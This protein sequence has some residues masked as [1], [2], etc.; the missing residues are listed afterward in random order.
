[1]KATTY[2]SDLLEEKARSSRLPRCLLLFLTLSSC[3]LTI[4][5]AQ[6]SSA[7]DTFAQA[8]RDLSA[9]YAQ[10]MARLSL[11][12]QL[13]LREAERAW[14]TLTHKNWAAW[15]ALRATTGLTDE[16]MKGFE[17]AEIRRRTAH[18][19]MFF[20]TFRFPYD[21]SKKVRDDLNAELERQLRQL[22]S[23]IPKLEAE[24]DFKRVNDLT[25]EVVKQEATDLYSRWPDLAS[26][27]KRNIVENI[28]Q[29]IVVDAEKKEILCGLL[30][31]CQR[32]IY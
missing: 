15:L 13:A 23:D 7:T 1:M 28:V 19:E 2:A 31:I 11:E 5:V 18:L 27:E 20:L 29:R 26:E 17:V 22:Q 24:L 30:G 32:R 16:V 10:S 14:I 8:E 21:D 9:I 25:A 6:R 12:N 4:G 3:F